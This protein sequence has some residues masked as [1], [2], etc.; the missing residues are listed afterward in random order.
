M[1]L[2][3]PKRE[4]LN[5][6]Y[7]RFWLNSSY[8]QTHIQGQKDGSVAE[9]LNLPTIR[10]LPVLL[11]P[12]KVQEH[13]ADLLGSFDDKIEVNRKM[14]ETLEQMARAIFKSWFVD[15]DPVRVKVQGE[16]TFG[17]D[18][19]TAALFPASFEQSELGMIPKGWNIEKAS[20]IFDVHRDSINPG[21][22]PD[23]TFMHYSL[24]AFDEGRIPKKALGS[25]IKSNKFL[26][27]SDDILISKLNPATPRIWLL[28]SRI[29]EPSV[30][31]TEF[32]VVRSKR[33]GTAFLTCLLQSS[34]VQEKLV[35]TATGTSNSHQRT[36]PEVLLGI[37]VVVP[38]ESLVR[39]FDRTVLSMLELV[40][41]NIEG[42]HALASTRDLLLPRILSGE[43]SIKEAV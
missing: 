29:A 9:R 1:V 20:S 21:S 7:L 18:E 3:R 2:I 28:P 22:S 40:L 42:S 27:K 24:P 6:R 38:P 13:I 32:M 30:C 41:C 11:P 10:N 17:I 5:S 35:Q 26:V 23:V 31:S 8:M 37:N 4:K 39:A 25:E 19:A 14:N 12:I 36:K 15:F 16:K 33:V 43:V 34:S